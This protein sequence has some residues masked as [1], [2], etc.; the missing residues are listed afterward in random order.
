MEDNNQML[1]DI[2]EIVNF[3]KDN[4]VTK[5]EFNS[6]RGE[7]DKRFDGIDKQF[8]SIDKRFENIDKRFDDVDAEFKKVREEII[9]HV[10]GFVGLHQHLEIEL[11]AVAHKTD[12]LEN[13]IY[14]IAKHLQLQLDKAN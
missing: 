4:S 12:R 6:Y 14:T 13:H 5:A 8:N 7:N 10:D 3:L 9:D 1:K 2:L 11:A